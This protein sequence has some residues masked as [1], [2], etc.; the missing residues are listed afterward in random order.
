MKTI[1]IIPFLL[2]ATLFMACSSDDDAPVVE[3]ENMGLRVSQVKIEDSE[4]GTIVYSFEYNAKNKIS[5]AQKVKGTDTETIVFTYNVQNKL[6]K[7]VGTNGSEST[8]WNFVYDTNG[9]LIRYFTDE[10]SL[11]IIPL[12]AGFLIKEVPF[13][14]DMEYHF[15]QKGQVDI[16]SEGGE[17]SIHTIDTNVKGPFYNVE[18]DPIMTFGF[19]LDYYYLNTQGITSITNHILGFDK[20]VISNTTND[21]GYITSSYVNFEESDPSSR[22]QTITY[23]Y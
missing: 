12:P 14:G 19:L 4:E 13:F 23:T 8:T 20:T 16:I 3:E 1:K 6:L 18:M 7:A 17:Q 15:N 10:Y 9:N 11:E 22:T 21:D 2:L 5:Q